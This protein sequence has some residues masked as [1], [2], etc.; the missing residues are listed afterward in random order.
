MAIFGSAKQ[1]LRARVELL[2][3]EVRGLRVERDALKVRCAQLATEV[4]QREELARA[5]MERAQ[6]LER[7]NDQH[8]RRL[9]KLSRDR[10]LFLLKG[11]QALAAVRLVMRRKGWA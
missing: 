1:K 8:G 4:A 6:E 3:Q 7:L 2:V 9:A 11:G 10:S 5:W